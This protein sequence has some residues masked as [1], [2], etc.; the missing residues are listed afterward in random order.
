M[1]QAA[2]GNRFTVYAAGEMFNQHDLAT[3]IEFKEAVWRLSGGKYALNLPQSKEPRTLDVSNLAAHI[4]NLD[5]MNV[6]SADLVLARFDG[7]ELDAGTV[8]EYMFAKFL[9][10]PA[11]VL[12]AD[13]RRQSS[14]SFDEPYNLMAKNW[15]RTVHIH[16]NTLIDYMGLLGEAGH[17]S[18]GPRAFEDM[19]RFEQE[20]ARRG[21]ERLARDV[22]AG[23]DD[24]LAME[25]PY[26]PEMREQAYSMA[27]LS[28]GGG[29]AELFSEDDV[30]EVVRG[31]KER[32]AF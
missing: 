5:L 13:V 8:V 3:N 22:I 6:L 1:N 27:R 21:I 30:R 7:L 24:A 17:S 4:R 18:D 19:L 2:V 11:V 26:P 15:P 9:G 29:F 28:A 12:R 14:D 23:F 20:A 32:G 10:K 31:L 25:S 16:A